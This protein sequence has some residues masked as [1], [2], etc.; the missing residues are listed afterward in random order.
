[1]QIMCLWKLHLGAQLKVCLQ[2]YEQVYVQIEYL[3]GLHNNILVW[4]VQGH[5]ALNL[6][7]KI[8]A[9]MLFVWKFHENYLLPLSMLWE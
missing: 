7:L 3:T 4:Q 9:P 5:N 1:M 8:H 6:S 2:V